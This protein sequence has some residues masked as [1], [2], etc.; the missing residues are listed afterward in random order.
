VAK[1]VSEI[2]P[3]RTPLLASFSPR[4]IPSARFGKQ[5]VNVREH[6]YHFL[7]VFHSKIL[8]PANAP[9]HTQP[10]PFPDA[11]GVNSAKSSPFTQP[12]MMILFLLESLP[13]N[14]GYFLIYS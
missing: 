4:L 5:A 13:K 10:T 11:I 3:H 14:K 6:R 8:I 2:F 12:G 9:G 1:K 7:I